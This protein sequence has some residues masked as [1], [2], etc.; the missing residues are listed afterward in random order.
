MNTF[1]F[2]QE[3]IYDLSFESS[4]QNKSFVCVGE[5]IIMMLIWVF[6]L[7]STVVTRLP[8]Q[9]GLFALVKVHLQ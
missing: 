2:F 1:A 3:N 7:L 8:F 6:K 9:F 4:I 5:L